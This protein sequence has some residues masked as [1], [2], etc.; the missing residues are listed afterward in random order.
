VLAFAFCKNQL[1]AIVI[2]NNV[3]SFL[4]CVDSLK[5]L[6]SSRMN[7]TLLF[8]IEISTGQSHATF[9]HVAKCVGSMENMASGHS[10]PLHPL[11]YLT[12]LLQHFSTATRGVS[13][14]LYE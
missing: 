10:I 5:L 6:R 9:V 12:E 8:G 1:I 2:D 4:H 7:G 14:S 13:S 11:N 3:S